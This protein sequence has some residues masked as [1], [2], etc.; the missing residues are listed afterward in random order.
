MIAGGRRVAVRNLCK[1]FGAVKAVDGLDL[2]IEAGEIVGLIGP[3]GSGKS[4]AFDCMTG[5]TMP[6]R[7]AIR[8]GDIDVTGWP[9]DRI[10][11]QVRMIRSFQRNVV[12]P[13][14]SVRESMTLAGLVPAF[15][16]RFAPFAGG[17]A[18]RRRLASIET[19]AD[20]LIEELGLEAV[21]QAGAAEISVGQQKLLQFACAL[22]T[23]PGI[24]L[25]DE[26][27]AGVNPVLIDRIVAAIKSVH[28]RVGMTVVVI[29]HNVAAI[30]DLSRRLVVLGAGRKIADGP[31]E[32]VLKD[33]VV[34]E[35]IGRA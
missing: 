19:R 1:S 21:A 12:F 8:V 5:V 4:T 32:A 13:S 18:P 29:E 20:A 16:G 30:A 31:T 28:A 26:P 23:E 34:V 6:D 24:M 14:F 3:N 27:L 10:A 22:M 2:T 17:A 35:E 11:R 33:P 9:V 25:L 7:G 15:P